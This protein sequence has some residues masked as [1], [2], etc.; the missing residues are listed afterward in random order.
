MI[1]FNGLL[2]AFIFLF[3]FRSAFQLA[4]DLIN[5]S[6]LRR[7]RHAVP[8]A[9][10]GVVD[11]EKFSKIASYT[12]DSTKFGIV[13]RL[14]DQAV[15]LTILLTG[16]LPWL[17]D[18]IKGWGTGFIGGGLIFFAVL[19]IFS[20]MLDIPFDLYGT[21][22]IEQRHGFNTRTIGLWLSDWAK[23][24]L[25]SSILGGTVL[26]VLLILVSYLETT[27][28]ILAWVVISIVELMILWL[29]PVL[30]APLFNKF[31]PIADTAVE[32]SVTSLM[33]RAGLVVKG[34]FQMDAGKRSK[35]T[36]AYFTGLG[37]SKRIVLFD[38]LLAS[39]PEQEILSVLA[40]EAGHWKRKHVIK[41]LVL[42]EAFSLG[43]L[44]ILSVMLDWELLY[45]TFGFEEQIRY[46]GLLLAPIV[47]SPLSYFLRPLGSALSRKY[48]KEA[49]DV[50][51]SLM[52]TPEPV[53]DTLIRLS[54][55]NLANL[56]PHPIYA[57]FNYS[58]PPPVERIERLEAMRKGD[59]RPIE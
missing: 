48:E 38:T 29:Y 34:V 25:I 58:H 7:H 32:K 40:H 10:Q 44:F 20:H 6:Y 18:A 59:P 57:W 12:A 56:A 27:W 21:F 24:M 11:G 49:D 1:K 46:V 23:G 45:R 19:A 31:E 16:L 13:A 43:G 30:I 42:L 36:N 28:W 50:A 22:V 37:K 3:V 26:V 39:H 51:V 35:H 55:D 41:Q 8:Q 15:L 17:V 52:G 4:L 2:I 53:R 5:T 9:F 14:F 33:E 54:A 47:L